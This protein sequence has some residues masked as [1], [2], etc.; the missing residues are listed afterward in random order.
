VISGGETAVN[1]ET[2]GALYISP[3]REMTGVIGGA[4]GVLRYDADTK[5]IKYDINSGSAI[6]L[7]AGTDYSDYLYWNS[8][9]TTWEVGST[10]IHIGTN[11]GLTDQGDLSVAIGSAAGLQ[12]Q[13]SGGVA[14]GTNAGQNNQEIECIAI[15][16]NAGQTNQGGFG[17]GPLATGVNI[18]IGKNAG[19]NN[20]ETQSIAIGYEAG[21]NN[22]GG[23]GGSAIAIGSQA[24]QT[25]QGEYSLALGYQSGQ[26]GQGLNSVA[27][28]TAAGLQGQ[29]SGGVAIGYN[30]GQNNQDSQSIAIG[31]EA[32]QNNQSGIGGSAI[33]IGSRA[34]QTGQGS[35]SIAIGYQTC[36]FGQ[37]NNSIALGA[38]A[39][40]QPEGCICINA[41]GSSNVPPPSNI[42]ACYISPIRNV[43]GSTANGLYYNDYTAE[44][45]Y[46]ANK[47]FVI[48][49]PVDKNK[50]LVHACLEGPEAGVYYRGKAKIESEGKVTIQLPHYVDKL[51]TNFTIQITPIYSPHIVIRNTYTTSEVENNEF[52]VYGDSGSFFWHLYGERAQVNTEPN[53]EDV[54]LRGEGPYTYLRSKQQ[55]TK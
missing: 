43:N 16:T 6:G 32:G 39:S 12:G 37:G 36:Q 17:G 47:T 42:Y 40:A 22:Q 10:S 33:A 35:A 8:G 53:K 1:G 19:Q 11:A 15:G 3:I 5:E 13:R 2:A 44:V 25:G 9:T 27:I 4:T 34:G 28:G 45:C 46:D 52:T 51:A 50:Y 14:I 54:E 55:D 38:F 20:Q 21:Q 26:T 24:G 23:F 31:Y 41:T 49:H 29:G 48:D 18:A 30:A 7:P